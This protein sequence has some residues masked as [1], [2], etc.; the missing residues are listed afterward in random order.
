MEE[1]ADC[2]VFLG[3]WY[4]ILDRHFSTLVVV[5]A[6]VEV[7]LEMDPEMEVDIDPD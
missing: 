1:V 7:D 3:T 6:M 5:V 2:V 4:A